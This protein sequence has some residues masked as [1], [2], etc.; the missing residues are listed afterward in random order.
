MKRYFE[1]PSWFLLHH[2]TN[3]NIAQHL[4]QLPQEANLLSFTIAAISFFEIIGFSG[5]RSNLIMYLTGHL[6]MSTAAAAA[7]VNAWNGTE[8]V[9]PIAGAL[10]ADSRLGRYRA[11]LIAGVLY[12]LVSTDYLPTFGITIL[13]NCCHV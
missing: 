10:A 13:N 6:G 4:S 7:S 12:L 8:M 1:H 11:V 5:V 3:I 9:L 2:T